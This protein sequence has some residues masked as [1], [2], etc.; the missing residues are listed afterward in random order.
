MNLTEQEKNRI[1]VLHKQYSVITEQED[2]VICDRNSF[3]TGGKTVLPANAYDG[4]LFNA[5]YEAGFTE[6]GKEY[7]GCWYRDDMIFGE[8]TFKSTARIS[9]KS[10]DSITMELVSYDLW[11]DNNPF[12]EDFSEAKKEY[13]KSHTSLS[14]KVGGDMNV[15]ST[16]IILDSGGNKVEPDTYWEGLNKLNEDI[17]RT[18][19]LMGLITEQSSGETL[20]TL[21]HE[22]VD[23]LVET[24]G[25][26]M[27]IA[28]MGGCEESNMVVPPKLSTRFP[29]WVEL[30]NLALAVLSSEELP[31]LFAR[32][33]CTALNSDGHGRGDWNIIDSKFPEFRF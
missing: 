19:E 24:R 28:G 13:I 26:G 14:Y 17:L 15:V 2:E 29:K 31:N 7:K 4:K 33:L 25:G 16:D 10:P 30:E 11:D 20:K 27:T 9:P 22:W 8:Y 12:N 5:L 18:K 32:Y 3:N 6:V 23:W 1:R 21:L